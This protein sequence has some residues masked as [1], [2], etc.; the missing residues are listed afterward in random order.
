MFSKGAEQKMG[1]LDKLL[2]RPSKEEKAKLDKAHQFGRDA[3]AS[4]MRDLDSFIAIRFG[5]VKEAYLDILRQNVA[6]A[7][8][9]EDH[10]PILLTRA[11]YSVF[12]EN[13]ESTKD[14]MKDEIMAH[15]AEWIEAFEGMG[16]AEQIAQLVDS[17][18]N[19]FSLD[20]TTSGLSVITDR[21]YELKAADDGWRA[22]FPEQAAS[23]RLE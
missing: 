3:A 8:L 17:R 15:R 9:R 5:H 19:D 22:R 11:D 23:E 20:M 6:D 13:V 7:M 12:L 4:M 2:C 14:Q 21:A 1:F 10:S 18:L 16:D